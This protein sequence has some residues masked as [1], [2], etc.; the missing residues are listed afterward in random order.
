MFAKLFRKYNYV[1]EA[2]ELGMEDAY[3][4][5]LSALASEHTHDPGICSDVA[6]YT[7]DGVYSDEC[8]YLERIYAK[9]FPQNSIEL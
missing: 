1:G 9:L 6:Y 7:N 4:E 8:L 3:K 2:Y 5:I